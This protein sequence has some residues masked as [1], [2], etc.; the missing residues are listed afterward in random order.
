MTKLVPKHS[1]E[2][3]PGPA[4]TPAELRERAQRALLYAD[5]L[6]Y[7]DTFGRNAAA[8]R[9]RNYAAELEARATELLLLGEALGKSNHEA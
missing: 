8:E 5:T 3:W 9:L 2:F 1:V 7:P 6:F 4:H